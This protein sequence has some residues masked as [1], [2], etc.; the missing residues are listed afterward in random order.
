MNFLSSL[1]EIVKNAEKVVEVKMPKI[2]K[3]RYSD[4][5]PVKKSNDETQFVV[6]APNEIAITGNTL[7]KT[8]VFS[9]LPVV[10]T[11]ATGDDLVLQNTGVVQIGEICVVVS[12]KQTTSYRS[13]A[14]PLA[15]FVV[16]GLDNASTKV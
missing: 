12:A 1:F 10:I 6:C 15:R 16:L 14:E 11:G 7:I 13:A 4:G 5:S 8:G 3:F 2:A 9:D